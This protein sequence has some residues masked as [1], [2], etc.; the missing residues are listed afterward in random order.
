MQKI[1]NLKPIFMKFFTNLSLILTLASLFVAFAAQAEP[2]EKSVTYNIKEGKLPMDDVTKY[3]WDGSTAYTLPNIYFDDFHLTF[4]STRN[5][6]NYSCLLVYAETRYIRLRPIN[7]AVANNVTLTL[8]AP[9]TKK[10]TKVAFNDTEERAFGVKQVSC[11]PGS[12]VVPSKQE[13]EWVSDNEAG[14]T[15]FKAVLTSGGNNAPSEFRIYTITVTYIDDAEV[16]PE[17]LADI[18]GGCYPREGRVVEQLDY[19]SLGFSGELKFNEDCEEKCTLSLDGE[20]LESFSSD[21]LRLEVAWCDRPIAPTTTD[22]DHESEA[23]SDLICE[24]TPAYTKNG[25]YTFTIPDNF[26][27][28]N[29]RPMPG[30]SASFVVENST[31]GLK[32]V[33]SET[34]VTVYSP[35]GVCLM[36]NSSAASLQSL[37]AGLY[38]VNGKKAVLK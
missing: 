23:F 31:S 30:I 13:F 20:V 19:L 2:V 29:G 33:E 1:T 6:A 14:D 16:E 15:E 38:I 12:I 37:P 35:S 24:P 28:Y 27:T 21:Q 8:S 17:T 25:T 32:D 5:G 10:V 36:K 9:Y 34:E 4:S 3:E 26:L 11:D 18:Y 22:Y 7:A